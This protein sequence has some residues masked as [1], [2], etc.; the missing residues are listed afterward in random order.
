MP[1][2]YRLRKDLKNPKPI[3]A[4][5][6]CPVWAMDMWQQ[7][8]LWVLRTFEDSSD[9]LEL[10]NRRGCIA[11]PDD[12]FQLLEKH[13]EEVEYYD[14]SNGSFYIKDGLQAVLMLAE[15]SPENILAQLY[16]DHILDLSDLRQADEEV[17]ESIKDMDDATWK[18]FYQ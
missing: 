16:Y 5:D 13:L 14:K 9:R 17:Q 15:S 3:V 8:S 2:V 7:G 10:Q 4:E 18:R 11:S 12:R 1:V 6:P